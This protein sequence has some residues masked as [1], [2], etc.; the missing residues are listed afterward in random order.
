MKSKRRVQSLK[1][2]NEGEKERRRGLLVARGQIINR[3]HCIRYIAGKH[4]E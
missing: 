2:G 3:V 1:L 4:A